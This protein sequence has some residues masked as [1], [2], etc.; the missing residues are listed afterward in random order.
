MDAAIGNAINITKE[1]NF[2][3]PVGFFRLPLYEMNEEEKEIF[4][5]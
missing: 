3:I 1:I 4:I 5:K 2:K